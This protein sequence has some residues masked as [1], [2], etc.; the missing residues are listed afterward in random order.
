M[1]TREEKLAIL[2]ALNAEIAKLKGAQKPASPASAV[3]D[4]ALDAVK[5][6][7]MGMAAQGAKSVTDIV[8]GLSKVGT[9]SI[10]PEL[11]NK[12]A[13]VVNAGRAAGVAVGNVINEPQQLMGQPSH[14]PIM[15][16]AAMA[17]ERGK[18][19]LKP[20]FEP[21]GAAEQIGAAVGD[22]APLLAAGGAPGVVGKSLAVAA[23]GAAQQGANTGEIGLPLA[24]GTALAPAIIS[25]GAKTLQK[26][27]QAKNLMEAEKTIQR[28]AGNLVS[29]F[30]KYSTEIKNSH[31]A[32][33]SRLGVNETPAEIEAR[34]A[35]FPKADGKMS[36]AEILKDLD[37]IRKPSA[38]ASSGRAALGLEAA[39]AQVMTPSQKLKQLSILDE[40]INQ[41]VDWKNPA[42]TK[43][44]L[45]MKNAIRD[46]MM[47]LGGPAEELLKANKAY[48]NFLKISGRIAK[49][50]ETP[51]GSEAFLTKLAKGSIRRTLGKAANQELAAVRALEKQR[52]VKVFD[53]VRTA[54]DLNNKA[55]D[56]S[57]TTKGI[58][59]TA[60]GVAM[61]RARMLLDGLER[62]SQARARK[63]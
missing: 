43:E 10:S 44:A 1:A 47:K 4:M 40:Q 59:K 26:I 11:Q 15:D 50:L 28:E 36:V 12:I 30:D 21:Q 2:N 8:S 9:M 52:G 58:V 19:A 45:A 18:E 55:A 3:G 63:I 34:I 61:P 6:T 23:A 14:A 20:G 7:G 49:Q 17:V 24:I 37:A 13:P 46:E 51:E 57:A 16:K 54:V 42:S 33:R 39:P 56:A 5:Q 53:P 32:V 31:N 25:R 41:H 38:A 29:T 35:R 22:A 62:L 27:G 60:I 48:S